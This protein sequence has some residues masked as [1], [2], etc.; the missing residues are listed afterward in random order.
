MSNIDDLLSEIR[1]T[2]RSLTLLIE[3]ISLN[4][5][6]WYTLPN[7]AKILGIN[8]N[9]FRSL[10]IEGVIPCAMSNDNPKMRHYLVDVFEARKALQKGGYMRCDQPSGKKRGRKPKMSLNTI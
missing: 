2:N 7:A 4:Q 6:Q 8:Y 9:K 3:T 1:E 5:N 10:C